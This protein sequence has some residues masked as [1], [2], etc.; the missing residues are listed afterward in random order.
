MVNIMPF[1]KLIQGKVARGVY[2]MRLSSKEGLQTWTA[3]FDLM[4][5]D[6]FPT[7]TAQ[8]SK[9]ERG[10]VRGT[11]GLEWKDLGLGPIVI[12]NKLCILLQV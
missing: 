1:A 6:N 5:P 4:R 10:K 12:E 7:Y 11:L 8:D 2:P 9:R 3:D